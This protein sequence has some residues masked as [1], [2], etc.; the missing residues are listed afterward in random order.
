[1]QIPYQRR[2]HVSRAVEI[3][4]AM[5]GG[6]SKTL[7]MTRKNQHRRNPDNIP[8]H[9]GCLNILESAMGCDGFV[10]CSRETAVASQRSGQRVY[11]ESRSAAPETVAARS[12]DAC[13]AKQLRPRSLRRFNLPG[14]TRR[15]TKIHQCH[16]CHVNNHATTT[17]SQQQPDAPSQRPDSLRRA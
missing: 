6:I 11:G 16:T 17:P 10:F 14:Q 8:N 4:Y 12:C 15:A 9:N 5:R 3:L 7:Q 1:M 2:S 13:H